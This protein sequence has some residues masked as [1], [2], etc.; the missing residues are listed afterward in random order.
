MT[1][2][3]NTFNK[4]VIT[5]PV[6]PAIEVGGFVNDAE[7]NIYK[8]KLSPRTKLHTIVVTGVVGTDGLYLFPSPSRVRDWLSTIFYMN[9]DYGLY[10]DAC[11]IETIFW[12]ASVEADGSTVR[13]TDTSTS[14]NFTV[15][16]NFT[17]VENPKRTHIRKHEIKFENHI[18]IESE[19]LNQKTWNAIIKKINNTTVVRRFKPTRYQ[20]Y[21]AVTCMSRNGHRI[22]ATTNYPDEPIVAILDNEAA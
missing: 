22:I 16:V 20:G 8:I 15:K 13:Y 19:F 1:Y 17:D 5:S 12:D 3:F 11:K 2:Y 6:D 4:T 10:V 21:P 18:M 14:N 9:D 7:Q